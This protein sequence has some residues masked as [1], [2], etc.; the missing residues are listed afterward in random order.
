MQRYADIATLIGVSLTVEHLLPVIQ[1]IFKQDTFE[2]ADKG[3][4]KI[5]FQ[6]L[7]RL[8]DFLS[9][10]EITVGY[11]GVRDFIMQLFYDFFS[12]ER[13]DENLK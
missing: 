10:S 1:E 5:I 3:F 7:N 6:N 12:S 11:N 8:I 13:V 9:S 2:S 4:I